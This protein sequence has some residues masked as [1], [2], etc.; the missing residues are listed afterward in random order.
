VTPAGEL[1][2]AEIARDGPVPFRRFME[3]ALYHPVHGYYR[4]ERHGR[5]CDP[6]GR[7]GDFYT[8]E[9]LQPV[10]GILMTACV[11][12]L[13][14]AMGEAADFTVV[15]LG[16]GRREMAE[17]FRAWRYMP[18]DVGYGELPGKF[19]GVVFSNEF[20]DA[21][22]VDV[23]VF[24]RGEWHERRVGWREGRFMWETSGPVSAILGDYLERFGPPP[25]D[26]T[27]AEVNL[28]ALEWLDRVAR[29]MVSGHMLTIDYGYRRR[30]LIRFPSGTLMSYRRHMAAEDVL[31]DPG[32]RDIT[33]HVNFSALEEHGAA[34][35]WHT[36]RFETLAQTIL[37][38]GEADQFAS[39][40]FAEEESEALRR[41]MQLKTLLVGM[42]ETFR[43]LVQQREETE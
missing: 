11:R 33:A 19:R 1:L 41:R 43:V 20:F 27:I 9:Q 35:G 38:A 39:V 24:E 6:F 8:A 5:R 15:E 28:D 23:A 25:E 17:A 3:M 18:I 37:A 13:Y 12:Q 32:E 14:R 30:E 40:L 26:G 10:F 36:A 4:L 7:E 21:L 29:R 31:L 22:P 42:G 2:A 16:A 34:C